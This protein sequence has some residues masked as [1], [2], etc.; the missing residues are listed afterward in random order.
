M[1]FSGMRKLI[2]F[3]KTDFVLEKIILKGPTD[4]HM[5]NINIY[6]VSCEKDLIF[7]LCIVYF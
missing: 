6:S 5:Y 7:D 1:F 4:K 2:L 3:F